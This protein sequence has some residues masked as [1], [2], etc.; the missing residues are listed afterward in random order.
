MATKI[1]IRRG[2]AEQWGNSNPV[3]SSG[4]ISVETDTLKM[5]IGDGSSSYS[6]L[7]YIEDK[8]EIYIGSWYPRQN[9]MEDCSDDEDGAE[10]NFDKMCDVYC[11]SVKHVDAENL[12]VKAIGNDG[13]ILGSCGPSESKAELYNYL[14][15]INRENSFTAIFYIK[16]HGEKIHT[17]LFNELY[18][19][20]IGDAFKK[21]R[22]KLMHDDSETIQDFIKRLYMD[23]WDRTVH[24]DEMETAVKTI[25]KTAVFRGGRFYQPGRFTFP[26]DTEMPQNN[27]IVY[28]TQTGQFVHV[29]RQMIVEEWYNDIEFRR[30]DILYYKKGEYWDGDIED[31]VYIET[32][33][34]SP[35][36]RPESVDEDTEYHSFGV[37]MVYEFILE[38]TGDERYRMYRITGCGNDV[39][40]MYIPSQIAD[41]GFDENNYVGYPFIYYKLPKQSPKLKVLDNLDFSCG[42]AFG[43][44]KGPRPFKIRVKVHQ[45]TEEIKPNR[46]GDRGPMKF[47]MGIYNP[48]NHKFSQTTPWLKYKRQWGIADEAVDFLFK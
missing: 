22:K 20:V 36:I 23:R 21:S 13:R 34:D 14:Q 42:S 27:Q 48:N 31:Y 40:A 4:E 32:I 16:L 37:M 47:K 9:S 45:L 11:G 41:V 39:I 1:Q 29:T 18:G 5:K 19:S 35:G 38:G 17:V 30:G 8:D 3:L 15:E 26:L 10:Y 12:C 25:R 44:S 46:K 2:T 7:R 6:H 43:I 28:D 24:D 33:E